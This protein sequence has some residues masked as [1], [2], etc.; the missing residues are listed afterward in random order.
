M[1]NTDRSDDN[2]SDESQEPS[3]PDG[4]GAIDADELLNEIQARRDEQRQQVSYEWCETIRDAGERYRELNDIDSVVETLSQPEDDIRE[5]LTV[6]RLIFEEPPGMA[7][8]IATRTSR[9]FFAMD[10]NPDETIGLGDRDDSIEDLVCEHVGSI[11]LEYDLDEKPVGDPVDQT[12]PE[13][14]TNLEAFREMI[15]ETRSIST[16]ASAVASMDDWN[17]KIVE[18]MRPSIQT[19]AMTTATDSLNKVLAQQRSLSDKTMAAAFRPS[20]MSEPLLRSQTNLI[21][22]AMVSMLDRRHELLQAVMS[23]VFEQLAQ[24]HRMFTNTAIQSIVDSFDDIVFPSSV[25]AD[26]VSI[27]PAIDTSTLFTTSPI[28][29]AAAASQVEYSRVSYPFAS[30]PESDFTDSD[31]VD[32]PVSSDISSIDAPVEP[33]TDVEL[34]SMPVEATIDATL[35]STGMVSSEL[36]FEIPVLLVESILSAGEARTWFTQLPYDH[37]ITVVNFLLVSTTFYVT[38]NALLTTLSATLSP[39]VR[40]M[41]SKENHSRR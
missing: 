15:T 13:H 23:P 35:P 31:S 10:A 22:T 40:Q 41:I 8:S 29:S 37:Q 18:Q 4:D 28:V 39:A 16:A 36:M 24:H 11:Y 30:T 1:N 38:Q 3:A 26:L 34:D 7:A 2:E 27:Q 19:I 6:Y 33:S 32:S 20:L 5:A 25:L 9:A 14:P 17:K 12:V 21:D